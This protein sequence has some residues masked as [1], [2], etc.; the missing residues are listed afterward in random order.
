MFSSPPTTFFYC[1]FSNCAPSAA[2]SFKVFLPATEVPVWTGSWVD[3]KGTG[4]WLIR[5]VILSWIL[6]QRDISWGLGTRESEKT[7]GQRSRQG[8]TKFQCPCPSARHPCT[9][10]Q[11]GGGRKTM[12]L[13][14]LLL[15]CYFTDQAL[16]YRRVLVVFRMKYFNLL[17]E[18]VSLCILLSAS[19]TCS[20]KANFLVYPILSIDNKISYVLC[21]SLVYCRLKW[22]K[23]TC[24]YAWT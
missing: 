9:C 1:N 17:C 10:M 6:A 8:E 19:L 16:L 20:Q 7:Q 23:W 15:T 22:T 18:N 12:T 21:Y 14:F 4:K 2:N 5:G 11:G 13:G 24:V 3:V